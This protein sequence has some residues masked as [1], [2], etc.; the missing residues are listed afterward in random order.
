VLDELSEGWVLS[1]LRLAQ[2]L[3]QLEEHRHYVFEGC[4]SVVEFAA[5]RG[6]SPREVREL[7]LLGRACRA[8]PRVADKVRAG[9][10]LSE[11][12]SVV[13]RILG[14]PCFIK[15][16]DDWLL[17]AESDSVGELRRRVRRRIEEVTQEEVVVPLHLE[18]T[19]RSREDFDRARTIASRKAGKSLSE[20]QTL[21]VVVDDY[22]GRHDPMRQKPGKRRLPSTSEIKGSRT[23]PA[24]VQR[25]IRKRAKDRCEI[26][27]CVNDL[28]LEF[29]HVSLPHS[30]GG[31]R[32]V[33]DLAL[34]CHRHHTLLDAGEFRLEVDA[35][36]KVSRG[37]GS[38]E[39]EQED[40][41]LPLKRRD[42][43][44]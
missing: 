11:A 12:A 31:G 22:L 24:D 42:A 37:R 36:G 44:L 26:E 39:D 28:F 40:R 23:I 14:E 32:E 4:A 21:G 41:M 38:E 17:W 35:A 9:K 34:L 2:A 10:I 3:V 19:V 27:G 1:K 6:F 33:G 16:S 15:E 20:G 30:A 7:V 18:V 25:A 5:R 8:D 13:G 29:A 43:P